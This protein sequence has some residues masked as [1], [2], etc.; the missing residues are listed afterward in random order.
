[1]KRALYKSFNIQSIIA[2]K[3]YLIYLLKDYWGAEGVW[4]LC[5]NRIIS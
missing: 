4:C 3:L 2:Q 5:L 1:M